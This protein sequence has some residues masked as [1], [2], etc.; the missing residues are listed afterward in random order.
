MFTGRPA[1]AALV[2]AALVAL[3]AGAASAQR[4]VVTLGVASS[5]SD[6]A[7]ELAA[8]YERETGTSVQ[9]TTG[10]SNTLARQIVEGAPIDVF[11]SADQAQMDVAARAGR[12]EEGSRRDLLSNRLVVVVGPGRVDGF[13]RMPKGPGDLADA[14]LRRLAMGN[15]ESVP[16]GVYGRR[17]LE[18]AGVWE[19]VRA[20]VI[21]FPTVR[22]ALSAAAE[23]RAEAAIVY[24]TDARGN[25]AVRVAFEADEGAAPAVTYPMAVVRGRRSAAAAALAAW[26]RGPAA[27]A[28]FEAAGFGVVDGR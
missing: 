6:V 15:P 11:V 5:L 13:Q 14:N 24:A 27:R 2:V 25:A 10:G 4:A 3:A 23:G 7:R 18:R 20:K 19:A 26:L 16:A 8:R 9:V 12:L 1:P 28:A 22:A 21:P 17:W